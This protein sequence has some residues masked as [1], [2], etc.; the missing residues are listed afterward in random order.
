MTK[1]NK[2]AE[3]FDKKSAPRSIR[4]FSYFFNPL[5][6]FFR[7]DIFDIY[8]VFCARSLS[9]WYDRNKKFRKFKIHRKNNFF[10][11][12]KK[13]ISKDYRSCFAHNLRVLIAWNSPI[14]WKQRD[15]ER[16]ILKAQT[17]SEIVKIHKMLN[18]TTP[19]IPS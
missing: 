2:N 9:Y 16:L 5:F 15:A 17:M 13:L 8:F 7:P 12:G 6:S 18:A 4:D 1:E 11:V 10:C 19:A 14:P 3:R